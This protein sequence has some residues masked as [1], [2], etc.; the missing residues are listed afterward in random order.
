MRVRIASQGPSKIVA[1]C[2]DRIVGWGEWSDHEGKRW[3]MDLHSDQSK[4]GMVA[5]S[6]LEKEITRRAKEDGM[7]LVAV[8]EA[9]DNPNLR[10]AIK[11]GWK[12]LGVLIGKAV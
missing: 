10:A 1:E 11:R 5:I 6:L 12:M 9:Q 4:A 2:G 3:V 8:S 7:Y